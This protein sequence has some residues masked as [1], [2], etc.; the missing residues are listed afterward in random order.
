M[1]LNAY[2]TVGILTS[3]FQKNYSQALAK[4]NSALTS[5]NEATNDGVL[6][7]VMLLSFYENSVTS[8]TPVVSNQSINGIASRT[9]AHHD[10]AL[11]ML[12]LRRQQSQR[13][14]TSIELDKL[15]RRQLIRSLLLRSMPVPPWLRDGLNFGE[16]GIGHKMDRYMVLLAKLQH[17]A[18]YLCVDSQSLAKEEP[19]KIAKLRS[20]LAEAEA[21]DKAFVVWERGLPAEYE[22]SMHGVAKDG[23]AGSGNKIFN[24]I[25]HMYLT[26]GHAGMWNRYR[27]L[28]LS[29]NNI[30]IKVLIRLGEHSKPDT[31]VVWEAAT[32]RIQCLADDFCASMPYVLGMLG[33]DRAK[34]DADVV[35]KTSSSL[36]DTVT[37]STAS[38]LCWPLSMVITLSAI[39]ERHR[40][41]FKAR[42]LDLSVIVDDG[43]L[44][45]LATSSSPEPPSSTSAT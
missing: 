27:A 38:F 45:R 15:I 20:L 33:K 40:L 39:P 31:K 42:L 6:L 28:R 9:F 25:V 24:S 14:H 32:L 4:T 3:N 5:A 18:S 2:P 8:S 16:V 35:I 29:A 36:K 43:L 13:T 26:V 34:H 7:A 41:Y 44:E 23:E 12:K 19:E 1:H 37:A 21:L 11:A 30:V 17:Q 22:Y 10:G